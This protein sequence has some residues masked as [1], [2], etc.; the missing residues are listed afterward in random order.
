MPTA[1]VRASGGAG[2]GVV[3]AAGGSE[4]P[5]ATSPKR[6]TTALAVTRELMR[7]PR[8]FVLSITSFG[9]T[10]GTRER[11]DCTSFS[12][13]VLRAVSD[14]LCRGSDDGRRPDAAGVQRGGPL[15]AGFPCT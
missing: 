13:D 10:H 12:A 5:H 6:S 9:G 3:V 14:G 15:P 8:P 7:P 1:G 4:R 2:A 11:H